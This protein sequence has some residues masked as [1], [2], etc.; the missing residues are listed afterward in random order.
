M[1]VTKSGLRVTAAK[2]KKS[3]GRNLEERARGH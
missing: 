2:E 3:E 1:L